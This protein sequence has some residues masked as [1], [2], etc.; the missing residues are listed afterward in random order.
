MDLCRLREAFEVAPPEIQ[1]VLK[2]RECQTEPDEAAEQLEDLRE[3]LDQ[4]L[5][6]AAAAESGDA[7][8]TH[9]ALAMRARSYPDKGAEFWATRIKAVETELKDEQRVSAELREA[10]K[11]FEDERS[12]LVL[13]HG[14]DVARLREDYRICAEEKTEAR[15]KIKTLEDL[16][17][18]TAP[19]DLKEARRNV[20]KFSEMFDAASK[21]AADLRAELGRAEKALE[22]A[23][24]E[25]D[26]WK[27]QARGLEIALGSAK[28]AQ[29]AA[30]SGVK[31]VFVEVKPVVPTAD[32]GTW[33]G[34]DDEGPS[35]RKLAQP[36]PPVLKV[37]HAKSTDASSLGSSRA[38]SWRYMTKRGGCGVTR[39]R[40]AYVEIGRAAR[41]ARLREEEDRA[42]RLRN[43][44]CPPFLKGQNLFVAPPPGAPG[45]LH[46]PHSH[47][48]SSTS[49]PRVAPDPR[50]VVRN[51]STAPMNVVRAHMLAAQTR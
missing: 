2:E 16:L 45:A 49:F 37:E 12:E 13:S 19:K 10:N 23:N 47:S 39:G 41:A 18:K 44:D 4:A 27:A 31:E 35:P 36:L 5:S 6:L 20:E 42:L 51:V 11:A 48:A 15:E 33:T 1:T 21:E 22:K 17:E 25:R 34:D 38:P 32:A 3:A 29:T 30:E 7:E 40:A 8:V 50:A 9:A 28:Q 43:V 14:E 46:S 24:G 26:E